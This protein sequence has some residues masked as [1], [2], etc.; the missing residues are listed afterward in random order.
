MSPANTRILAATSGPSITRTMVL[1]AR[2]LLVLHTAT[3]TP[4]AM[5]SSAR[6][7]GGEVRGSARRLRLALRLAL[8]GA[9]RLVRQQLGRRPAAGRARRAPTRRLTPGLSG[10]APDSTSSMKMSV[11]SRC[12][13][14]TSAARAASSCGALGRRRLA[15]RRRAL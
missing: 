4:A 7:R 11:L 9:A 5:A 14:L 8:R 6:W 13:D 2:S 10:M 3:G 12:S 1:T 15:V